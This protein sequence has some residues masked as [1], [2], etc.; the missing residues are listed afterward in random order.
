MFSISVVRS[1][2][3]A[4]LFIGIYSFAANKPFTGVLTDDMCAR[5]H[6]MMPGKPDSDCV[7][8]C[9]KAG[10]KHALLV[11]DKLFK[12]EGKSTEVDKLA[13]QKVKVTGNLVGDTL[14]A[15][16]VEAVK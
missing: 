6:T 13:A 12:L 5:K 16:T 1:V 2:V 14:H 8:S 7:R 11:G 15:V 3:A 10:S 4:L 9:V